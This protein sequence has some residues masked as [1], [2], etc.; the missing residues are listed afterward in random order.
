MFDFT[1]SKFR[2]FS[3]IICLL[4][5]TT[6]ILLQIFFD[7]IDSKIEAAFIVIVYGLTFVCSF[8]SDVD[9]K[10]EKIKPT[11]RTAGL[12]VLMI[13]YLCMGFKY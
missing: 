13:F 7:V 9:F 8:V 4:V 3:D 11:V 6:V 10:A 1:F 5:Y 12:L 2:L